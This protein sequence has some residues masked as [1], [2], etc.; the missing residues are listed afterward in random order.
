VATKAKDITI[1][2]SA[3]SEWMGLTQ[4][5]DDAFGDKALTNLTPYVTGTT[6]SYD[7]VGLRTGTVV[8]N[9]FPYPDT[10]RKS[11]QDVA[12]N[13]QDKVKGVRTEFATLTSAMLE[14]FGMLDISSSSANSVASRLTH[15]DLKVDPITVN[16]PN[17]K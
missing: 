11:F 16:V 12:K 3:K 10:V 8:E 2:D 1:S 4:A 7:D 5:F 14:A 17:G 6:S 13:L 9:R 15:H